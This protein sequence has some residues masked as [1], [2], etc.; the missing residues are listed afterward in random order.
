MSPE[1]EA[2][3]DMVLYWALPAL[4]SAAIVMAVD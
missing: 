3:R 1:L 4:L 2:A